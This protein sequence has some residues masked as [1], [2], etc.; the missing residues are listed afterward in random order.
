M[1][2]GLNALAS[3]PLPWLSDRSSALVIGKPTSLSELR[4]CSDFSQVVVEL[5]H[6]FVHLPWLK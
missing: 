3:R 1:N 4:I 2:L 5:T 6:L